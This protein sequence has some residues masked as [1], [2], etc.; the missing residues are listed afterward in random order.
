MGTNWQKLLSSEI[1][2]RRILDQEVRLVLYN[3]HGR[4]HNMSEQIILSLQEAYL[5][6]LGNS[7]HG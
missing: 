1:N 2:Q 4:H 7:M 6:N 5:A 3:S